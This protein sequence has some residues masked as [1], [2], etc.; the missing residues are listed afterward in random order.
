MEGHKETEMVRHDM[1]NAIHSDSSEHETLP[2][3][4][5]QKPKGGWRAIFYILGNESFERLAAM[6]LQMN[7]PVYLKTK[8]NLYGVFL[9][10]VVSIW[11]GCCNVLPLV[12]AFVA[13]KYLGRFRTLLLGCTVSFM[14]MGMMTLTASIPQLRPSPCNS[15][16]DCQQP[17]SGDLTFLFASLGLVAIG[18]GAIR[19]CCIA[20]GADQFADT[21]EK[22]RKQMQSFYNWWYLSFTATLIVALL[23]VIYVQSKISWAVGFAIPT[24][25]LALSVFIFLLGRNTYIKIRPQGSVY[26]NM[27]KVIAAALGKRHLT[28]GDEHRMPFYDPPLDESVPQ[29]KK[30]A[31]TDRFRCLDRGAVIANPGELNDQGIAKNG[32]RLCSLQQVEILKSLVAIA[33]VWVSGIVCMLAM[34][35]QSVNGVLQVFQMDQ[36]MGPHFQVPPSWF[37]VSSMIVLAVWIFIYEFVLPKASL[38]FSGKRCKRLTIEQ[39]INIGIVMAI[40]CMIVAGVVENRRRSLA[41]QKGSFVAPISAAFLLPQFALSGLIEAFAAIAMMELFTS[42]V[43][44]TL[45]TV[46]GAIFFLS[47]S[48]ASYLTSSFVSA[49]H[50]LTGMNGKTSWIGGRDLNESRLD[51]YYYVIAGLSVVNLAY[52]N[53]FA[54]KYLGGV[55][56]GGESS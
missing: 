5:P 24:A 44:E 17:D 31:H 27:A 40:L 55:G 32:W 10:N 26:S 37:S 11:S 29:V 52:F 13:E 6:S 14:G 42:H 49:I 35:Q 33:P 12:G 43:P 4:L 38:R 56:F 22:G 28:H 41:L 51:Y 18:A 8:Y 25:C 20:F 30:L 54:R 21:T 3:C 53:L 15:Q 47:I 36:S 48:I 19:P 9:I 46:G 7:L 2:P 50:S 1:E 34:D 39:R 16:T 45:R 23:I